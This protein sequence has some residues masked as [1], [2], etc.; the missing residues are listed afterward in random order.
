MK[1]LIA[2]LL[3][4]CMLAGPARA[5]GGTEGY[6]RMSVKAGVMTGNINSR[7]L[8][9]LSGGVEIELIS[10]DSTQPNLPIK[11]DL[12]TFVW[13]DGRNTPAKISMRGNVDI[14]HPDAHITAERADW[15]LETGDLIFT[16][17]PVLDSADFKGLR[18]DEIQINMETGAYELRQ[19]NVREMAI[20]GGDGSNGGGNGGGADI[21]G[22][23]TESDITDWARFLDTIKAQAAAEGEN[24]GKQILARLGEEPRRML[25][26][27][28]TAALVGAKGQVLGQLNGVLRRPGMFKRSAWAGATLTQEI[29]DL[30]KLSNQTPEQQVRQNRLLLHAAYP[31]LV[32]GL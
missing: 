16:G 26:T 27:M 19:G 24:P 3:A 12:I 30:L 13:V 20:Q 5:Q 32:K 6:S 8:D 10:E 14:T 21:P 18:A 25:T 1:R 11:A 15:N 7:R 2:L 9:K 17:N 29:E 31:D 22:L 4:A 23:L 28:D